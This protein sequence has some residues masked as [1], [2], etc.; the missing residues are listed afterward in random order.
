M[1]KT[2]LTVPL[3][4]FLTVRRF[5]LLMLAVASAFLL[6]PRDGRDATAAQSRQ[7]V[8]P[9]PGPFEI[10]LPSRSF[11]PEPLPPDWPRLFPTPKS[12][13]V[14]A[15]VQLYE[16][17]NQQ[18]RVALSA[19][20]I[21][22]GQPLTGR[23]YLATVKRGIPPSAPSLRK[24]R[25][26]GPLSIED[27][28]APEL[29][30]PEQISWARR[31]TGR[32]E[33]VVSLF[34]DAD[35]ASATKS[36]K[37]LGGTILGEARAAS[38]FAVSLP[39]NRER[40]LAREDD[41]LFIEPMPSPAKGE[42]DRARIH[43]HADVG[44]IPPG[45]P[46]GQGVIVG[47]FDGAHARTSH[48]DFGTRVV[49]GD[50]GTYD[51]QPHPTMTAGMIAGDGSQSLAQGSSSANQWRGLAPASQVRSYNYADPTA[52]YVT[53]YLNDVTRAVQTD[54][55]VV[56]NNSWGDYG[57]LTY[58]YGAYDGRAPFLDG[59][60]SG[61]LGRP[62]PIVFSGGN[63]RAGYPNSNGVNQTNCI[64][65]TAAPYANYTTLNHPK[66]A[67]NI[68]AVGAIDSFNNAMSA[69]SSWGPTLD[70]RIKPDVVA[71]GLNNGTLS[72]GVSQITNAFGMPVGSA[73]E[74]DYRIPYYQLNNPYVYG[75]FSETSCAASIVSGG[76]ALMLDDW[77]RKF[78]TAGAPLPSTL[79]ALLVHNAFDLN[80]PTTTWYKP[81]PDYAS[82]YGL[83]QIN[84][85]LQSLERGDAYQGLVFNQATT[86][87]PVTVPAGTTHFKV[88]LAWDDP[89]AI[90]NANP[91][92]IDDLDL[93]VTDPS[94]TR[95]YPWTLDPANPTA[96][97]VRT[98]EDHVNNLEQVQVDT[99]L[100]G[101][102]T[103]VV[104]GTNVPQ[105]WQRFSLVSANGLK[106]PSAPNPPTNLNVV[107]Q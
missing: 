91:A 15:I 1:Q 81:G 88:T 75:W 69:F 17:P 9:P 53:N 51:P 7:V 39:L 22:L 36:A 44:A 74:Q 86:T 28:L 25:W 90:V 6:I 37:D 61:S 70:G 83:V 18:T 20:G 65:N 84:E 57:C 104:R 56:M 50:V 42:S 93:V 43:V 29:Q 66:S 92:L 79:R 8:L 30:R 33:L 27:K 67:K 34:P 89:P 10:R 106:C 71:S 12:S 23:A 64:T 87:C 94:G 62:V 52:N 41:I 45:H 49:Q 96:P 80:D 85:T 78:P 58:P 101:A 59:V 35:F 47:I 19:V 5:L 107:V 55:V 99:P 40:D 73:N 3:R 31:V 97:A 14:H 105:S 32:V 11:T 60:I 13:R 26:V 72:N 103:V 48:P 46:T 95:Q 77:R 16:I 100:A 82:G 21:S 4:L 2:R 54:S 68:I 63:E 98:K 102:W 24:L 38:V 76:I